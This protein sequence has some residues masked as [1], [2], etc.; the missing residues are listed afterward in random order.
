MPPRKRTRP[1]LGFLCCF[2]SS[3]PPEINLKDSVPLQLLEFSAPMPPE[4]ELHARFSEL[5]DELDLTDKNR[6]PCLLCLLRKNGRSIAARKRN[7]RT[8]TSLLPAGLITILTALTPW[9]LAQG[10]LFQPRGASVRQ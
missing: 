4:E 1:T 2:S 6:K 3:E 5:V 8:P 9:Q 7:K 10:Q